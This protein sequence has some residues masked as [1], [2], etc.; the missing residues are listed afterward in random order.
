[1][2]HDVSL[3]RLQKPASDP[4][5]SQVNPFHILFYTIP[6]TIAIYA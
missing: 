6:Y 1:M 3:L 2:E 5:L 4:N